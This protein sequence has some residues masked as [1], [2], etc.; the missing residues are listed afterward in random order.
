MERP[1]MVEIDKQKF[2]DALTAKGYSIT[3]LCERFGYNKYSMFSSLKTGRINRDLLFD[4]TSKVGMFD[5]SKD[6]D[7]EQLMN[8]LKEISQKL[9]IL[10]SICVQIDIYKSMGKEGIDY[11]SK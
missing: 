10:I 7:Y 3:G 4:I 2:K 11:V 8:A 9:D 1:V 5:A 6:N